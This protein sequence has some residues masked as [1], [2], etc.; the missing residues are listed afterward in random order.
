MWKSTE[1]QNWNKCI[2][3]KVNC[4]IESE[5]ARPGLSPVHTRTKAW[6][7]PVSYSLRSFSSPF[8]SQGYSASE[9]SNSNKT[10]LSSISFNEGQYS[11]A[12]PLVVFKSRH[13]TA[14]QRRWNFTQIWT[15]LFKE[16]VIWFISIFV[17]HYL[18]FDGGKY[19]QVTVM[20][21]WR[22][23]C[24]TYYVFGSVLLDQESG[25]VHGD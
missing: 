10:L 24:I 21:V 19:P 23:H 7:K 6:F 17:Y 8:S 15:F 20:S 14:N 1:I 11:V 2:D 22:Y 13:R 4:P 9:T 5:R 12:L 3:G 25:C 16:F 18:V